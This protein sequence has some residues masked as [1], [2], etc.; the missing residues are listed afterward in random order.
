MQS[1]EQRKEKMVDVFSSV[2]TVKFLVVIQS[3]NRGHNVVL[4]HP[5][6]LIGY[7]SFKKFGT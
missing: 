4:A 1:K 2:A 3:V 5:S 6:H 7:L